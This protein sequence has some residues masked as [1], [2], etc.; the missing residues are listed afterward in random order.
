MYVLHYRWRYLAALALVSTFQ[1]GKLVPM[2]TS[3]PHEMIN[4]W[5]LSEL[6]V[7]VFNEVYVVDVRTALAELFVI[8][9]IVYLKL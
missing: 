1:Q 9:T 2:S 6:I 4:V 7:F 3:S 8:C 5:N